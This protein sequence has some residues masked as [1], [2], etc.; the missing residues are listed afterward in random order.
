MR[1]VASSGKIPMPELE[2]AT[3]SL[4]L[5]TPNA[6]SLN[7]DHDQTETRLEPDVGRHSN[8]F[9]KAGIDGGF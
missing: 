9:D 8:R 4:A 5:L 1:R 2:F 7:F 6:D 3:M